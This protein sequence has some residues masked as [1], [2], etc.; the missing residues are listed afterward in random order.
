[1]NYKDIKSLTSSQWLCL[2][3]AY[4]EGHWEDFE[5]MCNEFEVS[6]EYAK[7]MCNIADKH[8]PRRKDFNIENN[9]NY[10]K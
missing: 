7:Y 4:L 3:G 2:F 9:K 6:V 5:Q 1:M 10:G 8:I